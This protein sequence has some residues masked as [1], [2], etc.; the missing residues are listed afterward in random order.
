MRYT[1]NGSFIAME[2][3]IMVSVYDVA[4]NIYHRYQKVYGERIDKILQEVMKEINENNKE[5]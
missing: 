2:E 1:G 4:G 3:F 5:N